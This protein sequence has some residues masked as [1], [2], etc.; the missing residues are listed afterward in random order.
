M[1]SERTDYRGGRAARRYEDDTGPGPLPP[2]LVKPN[3]EV[4]KSNNGHQSIELLGQPQ[5]P[6]SIPPP[7][8]NDFDRDIFSQPARGSAMNIKKAAP[9]PETTVRVDGL[10]LGTSDSDVKV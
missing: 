4:V 10:V 3:V 5:R 7:I 8:V 2:P 6:K 1:A 9:K